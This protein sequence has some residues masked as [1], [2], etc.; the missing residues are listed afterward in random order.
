MSSK[1]NQPSLKI[2]HQTHRLVNKK[3]GKLASSTNWLIDLAARS[4]AQGTTGGIA[5]LLPLTKAAK[6]ML[7]NHL[8]PMRR[9]KS[10][11]GVNR[12]ATSHSEVRNLAQK[13]M[14]AIA[15]YYTVRVIPNRNSSSVNKK[16]FVAWIVREMGNPY[17]GLN[18]HLSK[19]PDFAGLVETKRGDRWWLDQIKM[20]SK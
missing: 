12:T 5:S 14:P 13:A 16:G 9:Q 1:S 11:Q 8:Q 18:K 10:H 2:N 20:Q 17:S 3:T 4:L 6:L 7:H 19:S 15:A